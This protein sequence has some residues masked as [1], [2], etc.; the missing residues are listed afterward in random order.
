MSTIPIFYTA[1]LTLREITES[2]IPAYEKYFID[3]N[4][5]RNLSAVVPWP[6]PEGGVLDFLSTQIF[7][8]QGKDRWAW[9]ITLKENPDEL[10]GAVDL[11]RDGKPENRG[12]W[13]AHKFWGNGY[14]TEAVEPVMD[15][16]FNSL[17][18]EKLVFS[19][20]VGNNRSARVK[21]KTG[22]KLLRRE[23]ARFVDPTFT[24]HD[25]YELSKE[26]WIKCKIGRTR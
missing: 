21:E 8:R 14:M 3:Y 11:W 4:V 25:I 12:F 26:D 16:A 7:P 18:F 20:A 15:Y 22:A 1:R 5:I 9:A 19:N 23:P 17:G 2:D 10:I 13:L 6:Y 24:E